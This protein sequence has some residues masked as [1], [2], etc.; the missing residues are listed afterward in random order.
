MRDEVVER[1]GDLEELYQSSALARA[2]RSQSLVVTYHLA[3][4]RYQGAQ[5]TGDAGKKKALLRRRGRGLLAVP[6]W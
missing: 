6:R 2:A 3:W 4:V 1:D 5:L